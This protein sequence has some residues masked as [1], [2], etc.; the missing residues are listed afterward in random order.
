[1]ELTRLQHTDDLRIDI[2]IREKFPSLRDLHLIDE[3]SARQELKRE[4]YLDL[5]EW[6]R[7][8]IPDLNEVRLLIEEQTKRLERQIAGILALGLLGVVIVVTT[9]GLLDTS[10][11]QMAKEALSFLTPLLGSTA[12]YYFGASSRQ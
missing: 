12:G 5:R 9:I 1:M 4:A 8:E 10:R 2:L 7:Q 3:K 6:S 11:W